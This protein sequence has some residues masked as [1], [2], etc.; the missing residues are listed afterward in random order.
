MDACGISN[1]E[2]VCTSVG[3]P[4]LAARPAPGRAGKRV[5]RQD[6]LPEV[7]FRGIHELVHPSARTALVGQA[8]ACQRPLAG[9]F[10]HSLASPLIRN[11]DCQRA[12]DLPQGRIRGV[13]AGGRAGPRVGFW[14]RRCLADPQG[15][16]VRRALAASDSPFQPRSP[17]VKACR[18]II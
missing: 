15:V 5:R 11:R 3:Q 12:G 13:S 6:C 18:L 4:I 8:S 17:Y 16:S 10:L 14:S 7:Y 9:V 1:G 2:S